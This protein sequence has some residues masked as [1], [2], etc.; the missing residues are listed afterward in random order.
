MAYKA[1]GKG[2]MKLWWVFANCH[3]S[4]WSDTTP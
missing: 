4:E 3:T 2:Y 1:E